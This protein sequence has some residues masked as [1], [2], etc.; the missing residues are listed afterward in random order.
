MFIADG[1][2]A[3]LVGPSG[4]ETQHESTEDWKYDSWESS[5]LVKFS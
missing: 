4:E 5:C 2:V 3:G 1:E